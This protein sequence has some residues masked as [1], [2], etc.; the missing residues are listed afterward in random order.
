VTDEIWFRHDADEGDHDSPPAGGGDK[1]TV[2]EPDFEYFARRAQQEQELA[3]RAVSPRAAMAH[4][5]LAAAYAS[6]IAE[7]NATPDDPGR[8]FDQLP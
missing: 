8:S 1:P 4:R 6:R 5:Y 7:P 2:R 3:L